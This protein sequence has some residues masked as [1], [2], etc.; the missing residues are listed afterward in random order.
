MAW[1]KKN[2]RK[3]PALSKAK[4]VVAKAQR[5]AGKSNKDTFTTKCVTESTMIPVQGISASNY[6]YTTV[7]L[8]AQASTIGFW[9][10][11]KFQLYR[12]L[13]D[14]YRVTSVKIRVMP[15]GNVLDQYH[16]QADSLNNSGDGL[17]HTVIDRE[18]P[19][20]MNIQQMTRYPSYKKYSVL[21][22]FTRTYSIK[23]PAETW[24]Q[25]R[26]QYPDSL[27]LTTQI[28]GIGGIYIYAENVLEDA[29][30]VFNEPWG[31]IICEYNV[32]WRGGMTS[33][34]GYDP[35]ADTVTLV[36]PTA[37]TLPVPSQLSGLKGTIADTVMTYV[38]GGGGD[39]KVVDVPVDQ[40]QNEGP[41]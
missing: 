5:R 13:Y 31:T 3:K 23:Y 8:F 25:S 35:E 19:T 24:Y 17:I 21:K 4:R 39:K 6:I 14:Q 7:P 27:A 1:G 32:V 40:S 12:K 30:E 37:T 41:A 15:K 11:A 16:A 29:A 20:S 22:P 2:W 38:D 36:P 33:V 9:Q 18:G 34:F 10:N 28:G 26:E